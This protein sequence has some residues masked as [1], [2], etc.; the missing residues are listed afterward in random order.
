MQLPEDNVTV[1]SIRAYDTTRDL[2]YVSSRLLS[3]VPSDHISELKRQIS[4]PVRAFYNNPD[5]SV[6]LLTDMVNPAVPFEV[7][8]ESNSD[9]SAGVTLPNSTAAA[10]ASSSFG[11]PTRSK[12]TIAVSIPTGIV[13][14][15]LLGLFFW[16][17]RKHVRHQP[18]KPTAAE[19]GIDEIIRELPPDPRRIELPIG[20]H[21]QE[22]PTEGR[23]RL[24]VQGDLRWR[25][26]LSGSQV[27]QELES[28]S[29][30][31]IDVARD[32]TSI[33]QEEGPHDHQEVRYHRE[34][35]D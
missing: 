35:A 12:I 16:R 20:D 22:L 29:L 27:A 5:R 10:A 24:E 9:A 28:Y 26:E 17:K 25:Q 2:R 6:K 19:K 33:A 32:Q 31:V 14:L 13:T 1:Q 11:L 8:I 3:Y 18:V 23:E 21:G 30:G 7:D 34:K 4:S 15:L